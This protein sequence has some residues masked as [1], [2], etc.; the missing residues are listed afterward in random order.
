MTGDPR[1]IIQ[2]YGDR[3]DQNTLYTCR[4]LSK[5]KNEDDPWNR[6]ECFEMSHLI[7]I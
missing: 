3:H 7:S 6:R 2:G 4:K 1:A 5:K